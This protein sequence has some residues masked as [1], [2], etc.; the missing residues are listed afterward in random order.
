MIWVHAS[1]MI[2]S[3]AKKKLSIEHASSL[4]R[5]NL[6]VYPMSLEGTYFI[7]DVVH[8]ITVGL[9][10]K[11]DLVSLKKRWMHQRLLEILK[12]HLLKQQG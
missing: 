3:D 4:T 1:G 2:N 6:K 9:S 11:R 10:K 8:P 7:S 5:F 12:G